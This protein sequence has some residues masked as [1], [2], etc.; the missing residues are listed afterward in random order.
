MTTANSAPCSTATTRPGPCRAGG[1]Q[2]EFAAR[3]AAIRKGDAASRPIEVWFADEA[4]IPPR[5]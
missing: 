3:L 4:R 1:F 2:K 5:Y